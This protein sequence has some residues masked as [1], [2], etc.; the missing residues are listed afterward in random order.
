VT[1]EGRARLTAETYRQVADSFVAWL[2]DRGRTPLDAT[3][4]DC[5]EYMTSRFDSGLTGKTLARDAAAL[6]ALFS[7]LK[8][9]RLREDNPA[10][11][12]EAPRRETTI[13]R[14]LSPE[15][16]DSLLSAASS[17][18]PLGIRDRC[19]FE[20]VYSCG[21]RVSEAV[22]LSLADLRLPERVV[23]VRGK[24]NKER[25][26][27]YGNIAASWLDRYLSD[28]RPAILGNRKSPALFLNSRGGRLSRKGV[29]SRL[30][31]LEAASG[32]TSKVHTLRHS[33]ATHLLAGGA[34]LRSVQ[35]LLG[36]ADVATTQVYTH[37]ENETLELYHNDIFDNYRAKAR[38]DETIG[39]ED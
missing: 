38:T 18:T 26:V 2:A 29:W 33:F 11:R 14:V 36:H 21:L 8:V 34:D 27:P 30:Q 25:M 10:S 35:E 23:F 28:S 1:G 20:L 4:G 5:A 22:G 19:L 12:L 32:V 15:Q 24:G 6:R 37:L 13:P 9:Q 39:P 31:E 17:D 16:V 7:Y 3:E